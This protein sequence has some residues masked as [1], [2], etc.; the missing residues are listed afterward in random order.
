MTKLMLDMTDEYEKFLL[1]TGKKY[2]DAVVKDLGFENIEAGKALL[3]EYGL[4]D[5]A[6]NWKFTRSA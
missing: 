3:N 1:R 2:E 5:K 6:L 4:M